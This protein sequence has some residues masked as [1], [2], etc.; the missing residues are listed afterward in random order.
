MTSPLLRAEHVSVNRS[1]KTVGPWSLTA[2]PG[3]LV[4]VCGANGSGKSTLL[5]MLAGLIPADH[6]VLTLSPGPIGLAP[7][8]FIP[9][10]GLRVRE[11]FA[12]ITST[13]ESID[14]VTDSLAL[15]V[16]TDRVVS[17][18]SRG[19]RKRVVI[20]QALLDSPPIVLLDEPLEG[21]DLPSQQQVLDAVG[22]HVRSGGCAIIATHR[23]EAWTATQRVDVGGV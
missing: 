10:A 19:E 18:L 5:R 2:G 23:P 7:E 21:L 3:D 22:A 8:P 13:R 9:P 6:G 11:L 12:L 16:L 1:G 4:V 17:T 20:A 14:V 15:A